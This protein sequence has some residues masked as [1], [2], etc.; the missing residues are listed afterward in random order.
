MKRLVF[1]LE[2]QSMKVLL[3][4][5]LP[6]CF[7]DLKFLCVPHE[8]REDLERSI[9]RKLRAWKTPGD[10][11]VI[12]RDTDSEDCRVIKDRIRGL[13]EVAGRKDT[14]VRLVC[15]ELEAWYFGDPDALANA[16]RDEKLRGIGTKA[17][18]RN[19]DEIQSPSRT[20]EKLVP[21]FQKISGARRL[22]TYLACTGNSSISFQFFI[23]AVKGLVEEATD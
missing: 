7:P 19:P 5:L 16:F 3:D 13:C 20:M 21:E 1:L 2:E 6:R 22:G 11:F 17:R 18:F 15:R 10:R 12:L 4:N 23:Q 14:V 8:G 9:P